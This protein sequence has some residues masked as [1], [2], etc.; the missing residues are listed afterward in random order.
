MPPRPLVF[1]PFR[2]LGFYFTTIC[3]QKLLYRPNI[4]VAKSMPVKM[5]F[6]FFA[7][8]LFIVSALSPNHLFVWNNSLNINSLLSCYFF[9]SFLQVGRC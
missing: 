9:V 6:S 1:L 4:C 5:P 3:I 7:G 8:S 2:F